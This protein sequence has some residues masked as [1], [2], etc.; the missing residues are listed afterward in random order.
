MRPLKNGNLY[1]SLSEQSIYPAHRGQ[2]NRADKRRLR[3]VPFRSLRLSANVSTSQLHYSYITVKSRKNIYIL[4][5]ILMENK[6]RIL[7]WKYIKFR[8]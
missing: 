3:K 2:K 5:E 6:L 1:S 4:E 7:H 8:E